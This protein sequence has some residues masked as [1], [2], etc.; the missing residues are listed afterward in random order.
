MKF[1]FKKKLILEVGIGMGE[2]LIFL[3]KKYKKNI[4]IGVDPFK[5]GMVNVSDYCI[6]NKILNVFLYPYVIEKF[7]DKFKN[8]RF[9]TIYILFPDPWPKK[10]HNKRRLINEQFLK[11]IILVL[12]KRGKVFLSTDNLSYFDEVKSI[13]KK[14]KIIKFKKIKKVINLKTKYYLKAEKKGSKISS[15]VFSKI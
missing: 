12:E 1:N 5:N 2:N 4:I 14:I 6:K 13:L 3:T 15:L 9:K 7:L 10:K 11:R 8:L